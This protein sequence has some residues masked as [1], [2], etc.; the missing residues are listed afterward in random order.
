MK[1]RKIIV[2]KFTYRDK[3][4]EFIFSNVVILFDPETDKITPENFDQDRHEYFIDDAE[5][6]RMAA[7]SKFL[8]E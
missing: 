5:I 6:E 1:L 3:L 8:R 7:V 4:G 2:P